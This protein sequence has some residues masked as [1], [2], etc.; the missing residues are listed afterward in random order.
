MF[1]RARR[2]QRNG[3]HL[4]SRASVHRP[5]LKDSLCRP[6]YGSLRR[7]D[8]AGDVA[9]CV[10]ELTRHGNR[11]L[12]RLILH[13]LKKHPQTAITLLPTAPRR[14][15][16]RVPEPGLD[17]DAAVQE[18]FGDVLCVAFVLVHRGEIRQHRPR[19]D[20]GNASVSVGHGP[21]SRGEAD[22]RSRRRLSDGIEHG[23]DHHWTKG[24]CARGVAHR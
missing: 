22:R 6:R 18:G 10:H 1:S 14:D 23:G 5:V 17:S 19:P 16:R 3:P 8:V 9:Q 13:D 7:W 4:D 2:R 15:G 24:V 21:G 20:D 12:R 11:L